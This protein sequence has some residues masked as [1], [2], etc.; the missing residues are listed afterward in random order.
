M[1]DFLAPN[2]CLHWR[3][4]TRQGSLN[5]GLEL[6]R[7]VPSFNLTDF[8]TWATETSI[9]PTICHSRITDFLRSEWEVPNWNLQSGHR[10]A[11]IDMCSYDCSLDPGEIDGDNDITGIGVSIDPLN[12]LGIQFVSQKKSWLYLKGLDR[13]LRNCGHCRVHHRVSLLFFLWTSSRS[14]PRGSD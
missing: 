5:T 3:H 1:N 7:R 13:I 9:L 8:G 6:Y 2:C 10:Q 12:S 11:A 14:F 4:S